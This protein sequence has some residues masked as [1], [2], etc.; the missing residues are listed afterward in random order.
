MAGMQAFDYSTVEDDSCLPAGDYPM[1]IIESDE[2]PN[3]KGTGRILKLTMRV[4]D[5]PSRGQLFW[6]QLNYVHN[7]ATAQKISQQ[8]LKKIC[9]ATGAPQPL[10][11]STELHNKP[12]IA[13]L[14]V[15]EDDYGKKNEL[16]NAKPWGSTNPPAGGSNTSPPT[17]QSQAASQQAGGDA[18]WK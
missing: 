1:R 11:D 6:C 18:P 5:G 14:K 2:F 17:P 13:T 4:E 10:S 16:K 8:Q 15:V 3:K 9:I 12:F 7:N